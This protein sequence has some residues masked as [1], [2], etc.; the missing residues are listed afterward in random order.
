[1]NVKA[2]LDTP[3]GSEHV[4]SVVTRLF[5]VELIALFVSCIC[6]HS[7]SSIAHFHMQALHMLNLTSPQLRFAVV[8]ALK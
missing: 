6:L 1:M 5:R 7:I 4:R 3:V 2:F 8:L